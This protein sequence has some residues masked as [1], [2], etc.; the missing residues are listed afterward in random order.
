MSSFGSSH[1]DVFESVRDWLG[2]FRKGI[3]WMYMVVE[4]QCGEV[5]GEGAGSASASGFG[6][7]NLICL[8]FTVVLSSGDAK[9]I[10]LARLR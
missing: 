6:A 8:I 7:A 9:R 10:V 3:R 2:C 5:L 4:M 1:H